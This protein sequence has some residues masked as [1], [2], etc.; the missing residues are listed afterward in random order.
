MGISNEDLVRKFVESKAINWEAIGQ[1]MAEVGPELFFDNQWRV[2]LAGKR[3]ICACV[4]QSPDP[5]DFIGDLD[6]LGSGF[7]GE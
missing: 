7:S 2:I 4:L 6:D 1:V 5:D 3:C